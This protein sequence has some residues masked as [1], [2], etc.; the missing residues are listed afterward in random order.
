[1]NNFLGTRFLKTIDKEMLLYAVFALIVR[2][3]I[4][5]LESDFHELEDN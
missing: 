1:M 5:Y 2:S 4:Q 3:K